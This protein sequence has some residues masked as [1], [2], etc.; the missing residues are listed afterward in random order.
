MPITFIT[1]QLSSL[2]LLIAYKTWVEKPGRLTD[3]RY[4]TFHSMVSSWLSQKL[5]YLWFVYILDRE[6]LAWVLLNSTNVPMDE[7]RD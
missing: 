3:P 6:L 4:R 5:T 2:L 7:W 1:K